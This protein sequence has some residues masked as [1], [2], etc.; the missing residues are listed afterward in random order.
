VLIY[1]DAEHQQ[2]VLAGAQA[3]MGP[4]A[5]LVLGEQESITRLQTAFAFEQAHVYR[6]GGEPS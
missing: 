6:I 3:A 2:Q 5:R 4:S 1:F